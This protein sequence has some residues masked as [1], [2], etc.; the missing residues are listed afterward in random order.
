[1]HTPDYLSPYEQEVKDN[2]AG[3]NATLWANEKS[4]HRR[5]QAMAESVFF[6][7]KRV[8]DAGCS[9]GDFA[10]YLGQHGHNYAHFTGVDA[11]S[12]VIAAANERSLPRADFVAADFVAEPSVL[13][14]SDPQ[15]V[16]LS[17][18]LNTM[19]LKLS[20]KVLEAS[21]HAASE[22]LVFNFLPTTCGPDAPPQAYPAKR[23]DTHHLMAW[24]CEKTPSVIY[25]QDYFPHAHDGMIV[26][27]RI[28]RDG[29][30]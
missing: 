2:G 15:I 20:L 1:M 21:W 29:L 9:R 25:R 22:T 28:G 19:D 27:R 11:V 23:L 24:A 12:P 30:A 13:A 5:F 8:L 10:A 26:M 7:G 16:C 18:T 6:T 4:Q 17:G 3:F 14:L